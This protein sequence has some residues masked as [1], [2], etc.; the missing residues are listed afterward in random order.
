[1]HLNLAIALFLAYLLFAVGV[2]LAARDVVWMYLCVYVFLRVAGLEGV[3][4]TN[5]DTLT[6]PQTDVSILFL[7]ADFV[8][9]GGCCPA[10]S[11]LGCV[12]LDAE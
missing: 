5:Q 10:L 11:V 8:S 12:L 2:E 7:C 9:C 1:M 3:H 4:C 6:G